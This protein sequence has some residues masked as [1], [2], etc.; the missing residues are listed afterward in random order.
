MLHAA[1]KTASSFWFWNQDCC[2]TSKLKTKSQGKSVQC[3][4]KDATCSPPEITQK[5]HR[6]RGG[7][8]CKLREE[9]KNWLWPVAI[10]LW[11][12]DHVCSA[13]LGCK[14]KTYLFFAVTRCNARQRWQ[15]L[16][17]INSQPQGVSIQLFLATRQLGP[18]NERNWGAI[19]IFFCGQIYSAGNT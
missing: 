1:S 10:D 18:H 4:S 3:S 12:C 13:R 7:E 5:R 19:F 15:C 8:W 9:G 16:S 6:Q 11:L 17:N 2:G 14:V